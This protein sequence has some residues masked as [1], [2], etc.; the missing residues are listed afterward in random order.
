MAKRD[1]GKIL[2]K[3]SIRQRLLLLAED[4]ARGKYF[5]ERLL[6]KDERRAIDDS[7]KTPREIR[8][9]QEFKEIDETVSNA[10]NNLQGLSFETL[11]H[12]SSLRGYLLLWNT[13]ENAE[14]LANSIL[15]QIKDPKERLRVAK[16]GA[17]DSHLLFTEAVIDK[18]GYLD[19]KIDQ[20]KEIDTG[21]DG[22]QIIT[23]EFTL[24]YVMQ[25]HKKEAEA[26]AIKLLSWEK[27]ILDYMEE[28]NFRVKVYKN[29][30]KELGDRGRAPIINWKK[31]SGELFMGLPHPRLE[32]LI[33]QYNLSVDGTKLEI[34]L[35]DYSWFSRYFL[36][37]GDTYP[38]ELRGKVNKKLDQEDEQED[39]QE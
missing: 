28:N 1:I 21:I 3:G 18:E 32:N 22:K 10:I 16:G 12:Y 17:V 9:Y 39:E 37:S 24:M 25:E 26:S 35:E 4:T 5:Q 2:T 15:H 13:I 31:Y 34:N 33:K 7:I 38:E 20:P 8:A 36:G 14:L 6:T 27:A 29:H 30:I 11:M 19:I 23:T